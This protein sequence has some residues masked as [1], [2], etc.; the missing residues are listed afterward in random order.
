VA[1]ENEFVHGER[2]NQE[3]K[4]GLQSAF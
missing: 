2:F 3:R 4:T 1:N